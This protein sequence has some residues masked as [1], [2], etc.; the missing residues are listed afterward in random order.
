[1]QLF[2]YN[3]KLHD[4]DDDKH[5]LSKVEDNSAEHFV[6]K[7]ESQTNSSSSSALVDEATFGDI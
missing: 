5:N 4:D 6:E 1:M 7:I 2:K 3:L